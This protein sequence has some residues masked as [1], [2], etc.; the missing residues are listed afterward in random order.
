VK[1]KVSLI[2]ATIDALAPHKVTLRLLKEAREHGIVT[3]VGVD[4]RTTDG[5][6]D[7][8][9]T[10]TDHLV[11][12]TND[13]CYCEEVLNEIA[14][15]VETDYGFWVC[16]DELPSGQLWQ[17]AGDT[18]K[19]NDRI[20]RPTI[21]SPL[22]GWT[23]AY[24]PLITYQPRLFRMDSFRWTGGGMDRLA[25]RALPEHDTP[26]VLWHFNLWA[27][28]KSRE[29]KT[30]AH[31]KAWHEAWQYHP[32]PPSSKKAYLWEDYPDEVTSLDPWKEYR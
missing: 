24:K 6:L 12:V 5:T 11:E 21:I 18:K 20:L 25:M 14:D 32:W 2:L 31:E 19:Y 10:L 29:E 26:E 8:I 30:A 28:R 4:R 17:L 3:V 27:A 1:P 13:T 22:P 15:Q 23:A 7:A 16:D 9:R